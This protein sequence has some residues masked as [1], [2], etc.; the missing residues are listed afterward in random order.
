MDAEL[1]RLSQDTRISN[2][3]KGVEL[4]LVIIASH[5]NPNSKSN[6][7]PNGEDSHESVCSLRGFNY[8]I[9]IDKINKLIITLIIDWEHLRWENFLID[10]VHTKLSWVGSTLSCVFR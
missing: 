10:D 4:D 5:V 7:V 9:N 8:N 2:I 1:A 3:V 6:D